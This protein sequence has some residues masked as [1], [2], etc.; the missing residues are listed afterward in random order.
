MNL[1][2][3]LK[4]VAAAV[5]RLLT[6]E[7]YASQFS[8]DFF[9][10]LVDSYPHRGGKRLR[11]ALTRWFCGMFGGAP[12][13]T[14]RIGLAIELFHNWSLVHD[15]IIDNDST[16]RGMPSCHCMARRH[17]L[18]AENISDDDATKL[19]ESMAILAGDGLFAWAFNML[20]RCVEDGVSPE[21]AMVL[22]RRLSGWVAPQLLSGEALDVVFEHQRPRDADAIEHMTVLKTGM[23]LQ[24]AAEAG[25]MTG[26]NTS[27]VDDENV[28]RAGL[29]AARSGVAFQLQ[30]DLL[31]MFGDESALGKST[32][33]DLRQGKYT[34]LIAE[35]VA[36][37]DDDDAQRFNKCL[38]NHN[39][40]DAELQ[41]ARELI[42]GCGAR[43]QVRKKALELTAEAR[44]CLTFFP[45]NKY[46]RLLHE[47]TEF[48]VER[49]L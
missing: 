38:G 49:N 11:P 1:R 44:D 43:E 22:L 9:P 42:D 14:D 33:S 6:S 15:D 16:R 29:F 41:W 13:K 17:F 18:Q 12:E 34:V 39:L 8:P 4:V 23:L 48:L 5:E 19:G 32:S 30:D 31:G 3:E 36:R 27:N 10:E 26:L 2:E 7:A 40:T 45:D 35:T 28:R 21:L 37:I 24:F 46:N 25:A 20:S 47:W